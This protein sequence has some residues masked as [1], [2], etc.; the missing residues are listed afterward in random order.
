MKTLGK[1]EGRAVLMRLMRQLP[2]DA[3]DLF[4]HV[5]RLHEIK[6]PILIAWGIQD[7][8]V[9]PA[10]GKRLADD[11]PNSTYVEF[12]D[13]SHMPHEESPERVGPLWAEF[14]NKA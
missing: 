10:N 11:L 13:L 7:K 5:A 9:I 8:L 6:Q 1:P 12:A 4:P 2:A 14:L 3:R